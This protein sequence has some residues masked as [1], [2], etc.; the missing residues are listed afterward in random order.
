MSFTILILQTLHKKK[1]VY[2]W[3]VFTRY[4]VFQPVLAGILSE[5]ELDYVGTVLLLKRYIPTGTGRYG[6]VRD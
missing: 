1:Y 6:M 5:T 3:L 4:Y 2:I